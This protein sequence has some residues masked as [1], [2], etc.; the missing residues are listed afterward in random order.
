RIRLSRKIFSPGFTP[1]SLLPALP[2]PS[3]LLH[4]TGYSYGQ[5]AGGFG[6]RSAHCSQ[7]YWSTPEMD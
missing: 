7:L 5:K 1:T 4:S 6:V 2:R 3:P